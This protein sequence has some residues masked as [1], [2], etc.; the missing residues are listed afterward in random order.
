MLVNGFTVKVSAFDCEYDT[1]MNTAIL[2]IDI[3]M[4]NKKVAVYNEHLDEIDVAYKS[5][6]PRI[7]HA[8]VTGAAVPCHDLAAME[9]WFASQITA[10]A[11]KYPVKAISITTHGATAVCIDI[12]GN[13]SA[14]CALYT[15]EP[16][17]DFQ[18]DFYAKAGTPED[19]QR[20][21]FTPAFSSMINL[22]K[23]LYFVKTRFPKSFSQTATI[24]NLPQY[25]SYRLTGECCYEQTFMACHTYLWKQ[26]EH[27]WS[28]VVEKLGL[29]G[30]MP[31]KFLSP[32]DTIGTVLRPIADRLGLHHDV[33]VTAG[34]HDSNA[35][36]LPYLA[37]ATGKDFVLNSTGT[38]CVLM[39]PES[40]ANT[41][42][43]REDD[44]GKVVFFNRS[45]LDTPVKTAIFLGGM[46]TD[47]YVGLWRNATGKSGYPAAD[48]SDVRAL[49]AAKDCFLLPE[50]IAGSGQFPH[51]QP[52]IYEKGTFYPTKAMLDGGKMPAVVK[53]EKRF[54]AMLV[55]SLV[56][57]T[58]TAL[59]HA[60][61]KPETEI[62]TEGGLRK[63]A[64]YNTVLASILPEHAYYLTDISEATATG[65]AMCALMAL[66]GKK[67]QELSDYISINRTKIEPE[68]LSGYEAYKQA[69]LEKACKE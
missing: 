27:T 32:C 28:S 13:Q 68:A 37:T 8:E 46:E 21:T 39:H 33:I 34:I 54:W 9:M 12:R 23:G 56:I 64:L 62:Y 66:T 7:V 40:T 48:I 1:S 31:Q 60:G 52:G 44:I 11:A 6:S 29:T 4:T 38:W 67:L 19:L 3:G 43:Y 22:A 59:S 35:S 20:E 63:N 61:L 25:L 50:L 51:A 5:F 58:E 55:L 15:Y 17:E 57:Q 18:R 42:S 30:K 47:T 14:P 69:W 10:F 49:L 45:A 36:L 26:N 41:A 16:G 53:N 65:S 2:V 24:L